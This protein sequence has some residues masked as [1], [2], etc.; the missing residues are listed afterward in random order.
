V[1]PE[2]NSRVLPASGVRRLFVRCPNWVG[3]AVMCVPALTCLRESYPSAVIAGAMRPYV[4]GV[5]EDGPWFDE[6]ISCDDKSR[7]GFRRTVRAI[8]EFAPDAAVLM[9]NSFRSALEVRL[10]GVRGVYGYRRELRSWLLTG[11]P[12]PIRQGGKVRPMPM[13]QYYLD[14]CRWLGLTPPDSLRPKLYVTDDLQ[15]QA[16]ALW[17]RYDIGEEQT[18]IALN[19]GAKFGSSKCWPPEHFSR[20]AEL[21]QERLDSRILLLVGPGEEPIAERIVQSSDAEIIDTSPDHIDL[22][23]LKPVIRRC[24]LLITNDTGPRHYAAAFGVPAVVLMGPT[25]PGWT[26]ENLD[27][28][29]VIRKNLP[30]SPC[31]R[32][33]CPADHQ[34]MRGIT[35]EEVAEAGL[36]LL[37]FRPTTPTAEDTAQ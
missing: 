27:G 32:K 7:G 4:R 24:D 36:G 9:P 29:V 16:E 28:I 21:M 37:A 22:A 13:E 17:A 33:V 2:E 15:R 19:P 5:L 14:L 25:D 10:A 26:S 20:L 31:H 3:D 35:P 11:G 23:L 1:N 6:I 34:C 18:V 8:R 30:C 12:K